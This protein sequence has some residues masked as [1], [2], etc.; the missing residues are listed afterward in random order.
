M[1]N[2]GK[3]IV[4]TICIILLELSSIALLLLIPLNNFV[5]KKTLQNSIQELIQQE[6]NKDY[7][8]S[9][10]LKDQLAPIYDNAHML[11][12]NDK[13]VLDLL[14]SKEMTLFTANFISSITEYII[15]GKKQKFITEEEFIRLVSSA[16]DTINQ[17][18]TEKITEEEKQKILANILESSAPYLKEIQTID[19]FSA[20]LSKEDQDAIL[21]LRFLFSNKLKTGMLFTLFLSFLGIVAFSWEKRKWIKVSAITVLIASI[22]SCFSVFLLTLINHI[23]FKSEIPIL[24]E[25]LNKFIIQSYVISG[26]IL[27]LMIVFL[28]LYKVF[29]VAKKN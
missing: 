23:V 2:F 8:S 22:F 24:F 27:L 12:F 7:S 5:S 3:S 25:L 9:S 26:G 29:L 16:I 11:G 19:L 14:K 20:N 4:L 28:V 21:F 6:L 10:F 13:I 1:R 18:A 15:T 17:Q